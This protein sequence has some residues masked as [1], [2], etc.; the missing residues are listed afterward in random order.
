MVRTV[1][2]LRATVRVI[3]GGE[4][5]AA[6]RVAPSAYTFDVAI[7]GVVGLLQVRADGG[8]EEDVSVDRLTIGQLLRLLERR[9]ER[10]GG[11]DSTVTAVRPVIT[12]DSHAAMPT[13]RQ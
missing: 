9:A 5:V 13:P 7:V 12:T 2:G 11:H 8:L 1:S 6:T 3:G 4:N 10:I